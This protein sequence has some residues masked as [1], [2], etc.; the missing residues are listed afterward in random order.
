LTSRTPKDIE[1]IK[2][3]IAI[4]ASAKPA[5][6]ISALYACH[7]VASFYFLGAHAALWALHHSVEDHVVAKLLVADISAGYAFVAD[8]AALE[9]HTLA[10]LASL[11]A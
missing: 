4:F 9:A 11:G 2:V 7:M 10:A 6:L 3:I 8:G 1:R 5:P